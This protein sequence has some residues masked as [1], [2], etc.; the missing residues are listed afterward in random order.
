MALTGREILQITGVS[1]GGIP[2]GITETVTTQNIADLSNIVSVVAFGA[3]LDGVTD[4]TAA[5]NAACVYCRLH[6]KPLL[7]APA[8]G[9]NLTGP[10]DRTGVSVYGE[11][12]AISQVKGLPGQDVLVWKSPEAAGYISP[13]WHY[14][15]DMTIY[16]DDTSDV[17]SSLN[18][19][20]F[21]GERIGNCGIVFPVNGTTGNFGDGYIYANVEIRGTTGAG[22]GS[23]GLYTQQPQ[24]EGNFENVSTQSLDFGWIDGPPGSRPATFDASTDTVTQTLH[25]YANGTTV[26][27]LSDD[28]VFTVTPG[29]LL[30]AGTSLIGG[31]FDTYYFV[32]NA[33]ANT[34]QLA[35]SNGGLPIDITSNGSA[36]GIAPAYHSTFEWGE[37]NVYVSKLKI[38]ARKVGLSL[39]NWGQGM[40]SEC[41]IYPNAV[42]ARFLNFRAYSRYAGS[43]CVFSDFGSEGPLGGSGI[44][45]MTNREFMRIDWNQCKIHGPNVEGD[46]TGSFISVYGNENEIDFLG[47]GIGPNRYV[48]LYGCRNIVVCFAQN[49]YNAINDYGSDNSKLFLSRSAGG[50]TVPF[51]SRRRDERDISLIGGFEPDYLT[52]NPSSFFRNRRSTFIAGTNLSPGGF[53]YPT[54]FTYD[55]SDTSTIVPGAL[56]LPSG[57]GACHFDYWDGRNSSQSPMQVGQFIPAS[58]GTLYAMVKAAGACT[59]TLA[60]YTGSGL[61]TTT[62]TMSLTTAWQLFS[63]RYSAQGVSAA[64]GVSIGAPS[65]ATT[66]YVNFVCFV[67]DQESIAVDSGALTLNSGNSYTGTLNRNAAVITTD[68]LTTAA[69]GSQVLTINNNRVVSGDIVLLTRAGGTNS[70]GTP[71]PAVAATNGVITITLTNQH[72]SAAFNGTFVFNM[73]VVRAG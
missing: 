12:Q 72:A 46:V 71:L 30:S 6:G 56:V 66:Y 25:G 5:N 49:E 41:A 65:P 15:R 51:V 32:V 21:A 14:I 55:F 54:D 3:K 53:N 11:G 29:G 37:D 7:L 50:G 63:C 33:T 2:S 35:M 62:T 39:C 44:L 52:S 68:G 40:M 64:T 24:I 57:I 61:T 38:S 42:M 48:N 28:G 1:V 26:S 67:P 19:F 4:N 9:V 18:R 47:A 20:G 10:V 34:Y 43:Q 60:G 70:T 36:C 69:S 13:Q 8:G 23:C 16:V 22:N 59:A 31:E 58:K 17:S 45:D 27:V 73:L